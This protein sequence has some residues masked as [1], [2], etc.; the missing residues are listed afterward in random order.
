MYLK[1]YLLHGFTVSDKQ[2]KTVIYPKI[3]EFMFK[4]TEAPEYYEDLG[5]EK[6]V[7]NNFSEYYSDVIEDYLEQY[8]E[9][10]CNKG[11]HNEWMI[12]NIIV[13]KDDIKS[14]E[15][16]NFIFDLPDEIKLNKNKELFDFIGLDINNFKLSVST[17]SY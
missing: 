7:I 9:I 12:G 17:E 14:V 15:N 1:Q 5:A 4:Q 11:Y 13:L 10:K 16:W 3:V 8:L 6:N 2:F